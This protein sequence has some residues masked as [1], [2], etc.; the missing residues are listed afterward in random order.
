MADILGN[1]CHIHNNWLTS[2]QTLHKEGDSVL[3]FYQNSIFGLPFSSQNIGSKKHFWKF[4]Q[5]IYWGTW[6]W[7][8]QVQRG[9]D[10]KSDWMGKLE[11]RLNG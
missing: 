7:N 10:R 2:G 5:A 11:L 4:T 1:L 3:L 6:S 9:D 8:S